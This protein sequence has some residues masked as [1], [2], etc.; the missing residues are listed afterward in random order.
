MAAPTSRGS[1]MEVVETLGAAEP[2]ARGTGA[3][4]A[5]ATPQAE[6][7]GNTRAQALMELAAAAPRRTAGRVQV[8]KETLEGWR[9]S[10]QRSRKHRRIRAPLEGRSRKLPGAVA[11]R[12]LRR[13]QLQ[14]LGGG[15][16]G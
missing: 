9:R 5:A 11:L 14:L 12:C 3:R 16:T 7:T 6:G 15:R 2:R 8:V 4:G 10:T 1:A 13:W